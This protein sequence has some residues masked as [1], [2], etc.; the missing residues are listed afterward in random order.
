MPASSTSW[1]ADGKKPPLVHGS[2]HVRDGISPEMFGITDEQSVAEWRDNWETVDQLREN[3]T[4]SLVYPERMWIEERL[5]KEKHRLSYEELKA[6]RNELG[7]KENPD[8][9]ESEAKINSHL[10]VI[11]FWELKNAWLASPIDGG[12]IARYAE[13]LRQ[14]REKLQRLKDEQCSPEVKAAL[15]AYGKKRLAQLASLENYLTLS[16]RK[17]KMSTNLSELETKK[18]TLITEKTE[19]ERVRDGLILD[20]QK[21]ERENPWSSLAQSI[22][23][24]IDQK[25]TEI[26]AKQKE[27]EEVEAQEWMLERGIASDGLSVSKWEGRTTVT[28][29]VLIKEREDVLKKLELL[30]VSSQEAGEIIVISQNNTSEHSWDTNNQKL[31]R[32][33]TGKPITKLS[34]LIWWSPETDQIIEHITALKAPWVFRAEVKIW[35][36]TCQILIRALPGRPVELIGGNWKTES[37]ISELHIN[38]TELL[39]VTETTDTASW[40]VYKLFDAATWHQISA[41]ISLPEWGSVDRYK[42]NADQWYFIFEITYK[43]SSWGSSKK[44]LLNANTWAIYPAD[45]NDEFK[46][47][48]D[49]METGELN[50]ISYPYIRHNSTIWSIIHVLHNR[51]K[52]YHVFSKDWVLAFVERNT[53]QLVW[54]VDPAGAWSCDGEGNI[55]TILYKNPLFTSNNSIDIEKSSGVL[56]NASKDTVLTQE[57][58]V[59]TWQSWNNDIASLL[60][61]GKTGTILRTD[62]EWIYMNFITGEYIVLC[63]GS[64]YINITYN[65]HNDNLCIIMDAYTKKEFVYRIENP[66]TEKANLAPICSFESEVLLKSK[67]LHWN[68]NAPFILFPTYT[69]Y[70]ANDERRVHYLYD[71]NTWKMHIY[72]WYK[73]T[74]DNNRTLMLYKEAGI[75]WKTAPMFWWAEK[76]IT[77]NGS[78]MIVQVK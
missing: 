32:S 47:I 8:I 62:T 70:W 58:N 41:D 60:R 3:L 35:W 36:I 45:I 16:V 68:T 27:I 25:N 10:W 15:I 7:K 1:I 56:Y 77:I 67:I 38:N 40:S 43:W 78:S 28:L 46:L 73:R 51:R 53:G 72:K 22:G 59:R 14:E 65:N 63:E 44:W 75:L 66:W 57:L 50:T 34:E 24:T 37:R 30:W 33:D 6:S 11:T 26:E 4:T 5:E 71:M 52:K 42:S 18:S 9:A 2:I 29:N 61:I 23:K 49:E 69:T 55:I 21:E 39:L 76:E 12:E 54:Y 64:D 19:L 13:L 48:G 17:S 31:L 74:G 20:Q